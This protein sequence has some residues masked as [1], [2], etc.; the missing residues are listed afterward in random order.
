MKERQAPEVN[1][2]QAGRAAGAGQRQW[3]FT[4]ILGGLAAVGPFS[5][6]TYLPAMPAI[7]RALDASPVAVQQTL[8]L[9]MLAFAVM[10]LFHG[11]LSD[12]FG[13]RR[14]I[15]VSLVI[16]TLASA[17]AV[18]AGSLP[19]LLLFRVLQG[20]SAGSGVVVG[21]AIIRDQFKGREAQEALS[22]VTMVFAI[23]PAA[24][25]ILGGWLQA[26]LGWRA[27][28]VFLTAMGLV[29]GVTCW[30]ALPETLPKAERHPFHPATIVRHYWQALVHPRFILLSLSIGF[31]SAGYFV[32]IASAP[33]FIIHVLHLPATAFAWL[34]I[35]IV[36]GLL[37]GSWLSARLGFKW[38][39]QKIIGTG[40]TIMGAAAAV[41]LTYNLLAVAAVPWAVL[42]LAFY[43]FGASLMMPALTLLILDIFP[44]M[45][46]LAASLQAFIQMLIY[47]LVSGALAPLLFG[48]GQRLAI[49]MAGLLVLSL[50]CWFMHYATRK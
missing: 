5:I 49:G 18:L 22:H 31:L 11:T 10:M 14:V 9:Y 25:P 32:Y 13:R 23:S 45:K 21:R 30:R 16:Y 50:F 7:G 29:L 3:L 12:A 8:S 39:P 27:V 35:P 4:L 19:A 24:A 2:M 26:F 42:P 20:I 38:S 48:N 46:G 41:N 28:F 36:C 44:T 15:L 6:D 37:V 33:D 34:F 47:S 1:D 40:F 17:G 43:N